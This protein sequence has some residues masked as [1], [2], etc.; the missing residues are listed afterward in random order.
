MHGE[1]EHLRASAQIAR[2]L[3]IPTQLVG[4]N[5]DLF[6]LAEGTVER[7]VVEAGVLTVDSYGK[8]LVSLSGLADFTAVALLA[9][10]NH[11]PG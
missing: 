2:E 9:G 4:A 7:N 10:P 1:P 11:Q 6:N 5:G 3:G 8:L